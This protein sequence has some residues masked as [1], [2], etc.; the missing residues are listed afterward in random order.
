M[1]WRSACLVIGSL[2][3]AK[4]WGAKGWGAKGWGAKGW[5]VIGAGALICALLAGCVHRP[6]PPPPPAVHYVLEPAWHVGDL[7]YYPR[8][9]FSFDQTGLA[10]VIGADHPALTTDDETFD[11]N[12]MAAAMQAVQLP[13]IATVTDLDTG[14][15]VMVRV[16]DR[17]PADP[18]RLIAVTPR[19]AALL[20]I[21]GVARVRVQFDAPLSMALSRQVQRGGG[22][23]AIEAA[24]RGTVTQTTLAPLAGS[25]EETARGVREA[26]QVAQAA[27]PRE[28]TV[29]LHLPERVTQSY[30]EPGTLMIEAGSFTHESA[31]RTRQE[32]IL[33]A[34]ARLVRSRSGGVTTYSVEA[35]PYE[36]VGAADTALAAML[37]DGVRDARIVVDLR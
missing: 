15:A 1:R 5:G 34:G 31:A 7:W 32:A 29:P 25:S 33:D 3:D 2:A 14:R 9:Q 36:D 26:P 20:G 11:P 28:L 23:L 12:A 10:S 24:P 27:A 19:V 6:K 30:V 35:G 37:R 13:A 4:G 21:R 17:G 18:G 8:E 16:N 22:D